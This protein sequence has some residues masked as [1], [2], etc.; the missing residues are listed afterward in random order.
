M[1]YNY[2]ILHFIMFCTFFQKMWYL[3]KTKKKNCHPFLIVNN[4][5]I[6]IILKRTFWVLFIAVFLSLIY[7]RGY[8]NYLV[9][10][11][12]KSDIVNGW[13]F[14]NN[15]TRYFSRTFLCQKPSNYL[16]NYPQ[17]GKGNQTSH[18]D[19]PP[20]ISFLWMCNCHQLKKIKIVIKRIS[21]SPKFIVTQKRR[22]SFFECDKWLLSYNYRVKNWEIKN[23]H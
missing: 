15:F 19:A 9:I 17:N 12:L 22:I 11:K 3:K 18:M 8:L 4:V 1:L 6:N 20:K 16:L 5:T 21:K 13:S 10:Q 23:V 2:Y 7:D 14:H